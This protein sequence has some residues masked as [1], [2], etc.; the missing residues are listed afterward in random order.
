MSPDAWAVVILALVAVAL[1]I[2]VSRQQVATERA[3]TTEEGYSAWLEDQLWDAKVWEHQLPE[4]TPPAEQWRQGLW[5]YY[6]AERAELLE[7]TS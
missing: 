7:V 4:D 1:I 3:L 6:L 5:A 2:W